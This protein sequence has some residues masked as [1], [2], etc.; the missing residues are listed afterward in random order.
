MD[1][2]L[3]KNTITLYGKSTKYDLLLKKL[4]NLP[5]DDL[6]QFISNRG[7][8]LP[9]KMN[10]MAM[11]SV[12]NKKIKYLHSNSLSREYF[13]R[14]Q[15]YKDF[16]ETQLT[17]LFKELCNDDDYYQYRYNLYN[18]ILT[19]YEALELNDYYI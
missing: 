6:Y 15:Y 14:L 16:G 7:I 4:A 9:R 3:E 1:I 5:G 19:N 18:L 11:V 8:A 2:N 17:E 10:C 12:L 13:Q